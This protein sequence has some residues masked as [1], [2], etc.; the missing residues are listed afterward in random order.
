MVVVKVGWKLPGEV[1]GGPPG[2]GLRGGPGGVTT[3]NAEGCEVEG[4]VGGG[5]GGVTAG[6]VEG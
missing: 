5:S 6:V 1:G 2:P 3:G 4:S